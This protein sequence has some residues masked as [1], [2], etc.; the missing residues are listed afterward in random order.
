MSEVHHMA[1]HLIRRLHQISVAVFTDRM[2]RE[3][4]DLTPVQFAAMSILAEQPGLDQA[5]LAGLIAYDRATLGGVVDRLE[6]KGLI[7]RRVSEKDRRARVL[8]LTAAGEALHA[9]AHPIA[10]ELQHDILSGLTAEER[11][12]MVRLLGKATQSGNAKS[13]APLASGLE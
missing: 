12:E 6:A 13:R 11:E 10:A 2:A 8:R 5:T 3:G 9:A 1:G 4:L 7:D